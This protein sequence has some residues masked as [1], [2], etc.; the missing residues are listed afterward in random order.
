M[1]GTL[2][3]EIPTTMHFHLK[4]TPFVHD[5]LPYIGRKQLEK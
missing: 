3:F 5:C 4:I 1:L 2:V